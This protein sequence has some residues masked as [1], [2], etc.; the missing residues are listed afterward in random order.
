[1]S[2][3][4]AEP[5]TYPVVAVEEAAFPAMVPPVAR[6]ATLGSFGFV[7]FNSVKKFLKRDT[8]KALLGKQRL[9]ENN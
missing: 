2:A 5:G 4:V 8:K 6:I 1:M 9:Q 3:T 7:T